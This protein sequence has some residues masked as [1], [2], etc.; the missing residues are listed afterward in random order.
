MELEQRCGAHWTRIGVGVGVRLTGQQQ[1]NEHTCGVQQFVARAPQASTHTASS[2]GSRRQQTATCA[3][4]RCC[5][6]FSKAAAVDW[7]LAWVLALA[8][9]FALILVANPAIKLSSRLVPSRLAAGVVDAI[10]RPPKS[11]HL[12]RWLNS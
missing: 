9:A 10:D 11:T 4:G 2:E 8:L 12:S 7:A 3:D 1:A 6:R 5:C